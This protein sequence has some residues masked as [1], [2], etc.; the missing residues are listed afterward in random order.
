MKLIF[1]SNSF[2]FRRFGTKIW[3][4]R[5]DNHLKYLLNNCVFV[6]KM[7]VSLTIHL[8]FK[9]EIIGLDEKRILFVILLDHYL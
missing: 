2:H 7:K 3:L 8:V 4:Q 9:N 6:V 5:D 1:S